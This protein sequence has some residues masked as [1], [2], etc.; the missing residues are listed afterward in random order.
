VEV[1][2]HVVA[3]GEVT[4][5][6]EVV[7]TPGQ[8][9]RVDADPV[10]CLDPDASAAMVAEIDA[11]KRDRDTLGGVVEVLAYGVPPGLG[12]HVHWDRRLDARLAGALCSIPAVKGV[13]IGDAFTQARSRGSVAHDEILPTPDGVRRA[14]NRAG[15]LERAT[16]PGEPLRAQAAMN[17]ISPPVQPL[18]TGH[19]PSR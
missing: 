12:S 14:T 7:P 5:P 3:I 6:P 1:V 10:R 19:V 13:E 16:T 2:S 11:A 15:R 8:M 17:P 9:D 4:V 18:H